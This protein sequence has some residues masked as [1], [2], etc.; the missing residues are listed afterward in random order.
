MTGRL[1]RV[2]VS[3]V[4]NE[5][6]KAISIQSN[7]FLFSKKKKI[8]SAQKRKSNQNQPTK[9]KWAKKKENNKGNSF[10]GT[11]TS[12]KVKIVSFALCCFLCSK[13]FC[14]KNKLAW[15]CLDSLIYTT[16]DWNSRKKE[17]VLNVKTLRQ[18]NK[19]KLNKSKTKEFVKCIVNVFCKLFQENVF[20][21][22]CILL[23]KWVNCIINLFFRYFCSILCDFFPQ[24]LSRFLIIHFISFEMTP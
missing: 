1:I 7:S 5:A 19:S 9:Q 24:N 13:S 23:F 8:L 14:R 21:L 3:T 15:T 4:V 2:H 16:T 22:N 20:S 10:S 6:V 18:L 12:K 17:F 11:K